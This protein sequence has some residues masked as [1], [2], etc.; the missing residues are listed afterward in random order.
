MIERMPDWPAAMTGEM[1]LAYTGV[2]EAQLREWEC[3]GTVRFCMRGPRGA[4]IAARS[5][6]FAIHMFAV[7]I[8]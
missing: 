5:S 2:A 4:A 8:A 6:L 3:R 7:F 1:A